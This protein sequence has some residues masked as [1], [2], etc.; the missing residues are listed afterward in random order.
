[1]K[2]FLFSALAILMFSSISA[3]RFYYVETNNL[4]DRL[5]KAGLE[6]SDQYVVASAIG[7]DYTVRTK[8]VTGRDDGELN[9]EIS[10][11]DSV[12][13]KEIFRT[14]E[15][16]CFTN[17]NRQPELFY[18]VVIRSFLQRRIGELIISA[19][20]DHAGMFR[21]QLKARKDNT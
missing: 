11:A 18:S 5:L 17:V 6:K 7:S 4:V 13:Q 14:R 8:L 2:S 1:M 15:Q 20:Q 21:E 19:R 10:L 12:T 3:Q 16:F 9:L